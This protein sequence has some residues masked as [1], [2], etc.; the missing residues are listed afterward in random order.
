VIQFYVVQKTTLQPHTQRGIW[1]FNA[2][3]CCDCSAYLLSLG[4]QG[5]QIVGD[6][7][8]FF[9]KVTRFAI[10]Q[11]EMQEKKGKR[12]GERQ[13]FEKTGKAD[14]FAKE[15]PTSVEQ[16]MDHSHS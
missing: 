10:Q 8:Q 9:L 13:H 6:I 16:S 7:F 3:K 12:R 14:I 1:L 4:L 2:D 15:T 5:L 11:Q